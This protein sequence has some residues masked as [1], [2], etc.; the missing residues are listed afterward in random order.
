M[1]IQKEHFFIYQALTSITSISFWGALVYYFYAL[2]FLGMII[3]LSLT[4]I[5]LNVINKHCLHNPDKNKIVGK[6]IPTKITLRKNL[7]L[8]SQLI[9]NLAFIILSYKVLLGHTSAGSIISPWQVLPNSFFII[10][11]LSILLTIFN[12]KNL[13]KLPDAQ[14]I[15]LTK[16][17][18]LFLIYF[19]SFSIATIIYKIG[20]GFDPFIHQAALK[21]ILDKGLIE[22]KSPYYLGQYALEFFAYRFTPFSIASID[23]LLLPFLSALFLPLTLNTVFKNYRLKNSSILTLSL[24]IIPY[25]FLIVTTPQGLTYL[26]LI[27]Q[28]LLSLNYFKNKT[29]LDLT[30]IYLLALATLVTQP[31]TGIPAILFALLIT[32][33][34]YEFKKQRLVNLAIYSS[35]IL[36]L[37][38]LFFILNQS[39]KLPDQNIIDL[40]TLIGSLKLINAPLLPSKGD[41]FLNFVYLYGNNILIFILAL[42]AFG[43]NAIKSK[44]KKPKIYLYVSLS[45]FFAYLLTSLINFNFLIDYEKSNYSERILLLSGLFLLP[46]LIFGLDEIISRVFRE[47]RKTRIILAVFLAILNT[48]TLYLSYPRYDR[49]YN[50]RGYSTGSLDIKTVNWINNNAK[51]KN[52]IVLANQQVSAASLHEFGFKKYYKI[53]SG[54]Q[55]FYYPIP[56]GGP[57][58]QTYLEMIYQ[59][60]SHIAMQKA[61]KLTG[62]DTGYLVINKYWWAFS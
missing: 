40:N 17:L 15:R 14:V 24:L 11:G 16:R 23:K 42:I 58:Y 57:L 22:P 26:F 3:A 45:L 38:L 21:E 30:L 33:S 13:D 10:Y 48:S 46:Y 8:F 34:Q 37:P 51:N 55:I 54:E 41:V 60:P 49:Y 2:N 29:K 50:S 20:Y 53:S 1:Q 18:L 52:Y 35:L 47:D 44:L 7:F 28:I 12:L 36:I 31:I 19:L 6:N 27:L 9:L 62:A 59:E 4:I 39:T 61:L 43:V 56:T 32:L 5:T 25:S